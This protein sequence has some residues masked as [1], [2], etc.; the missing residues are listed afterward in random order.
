[1]A[2]RAH[3]SS[4]LSSSRTPDQLRVPRSEHLVH[5]SRRRCF[6]HNQRPEHLT[7]RRP[8]LDVARRAHLWPRTWSTYRRSQ[9]ER[10]SLAVTSDG[11]VGPSGVVLRALS[12][13]GGD[14]VRRP[15]STC[16]VH[17]LFDGE[18]IAGSI[19]ASDAA[20]EPG[21]EVGEFLCTRLFSFWGTPQPKAAQ[22]KDP[23]SGDGDSER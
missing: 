23:K 11:K 18:R 19:M 8:R 22:G 16:T 21:E 15:R 17:G 7:C 20:N 9:Y 3:R 2:R 10:Y 5:F 4:I 14:N 1:M 13:P 6:E 12:G